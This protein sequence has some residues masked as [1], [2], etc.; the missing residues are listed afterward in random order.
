VPSVLSAWWPFMLNMASSSD[1][2]ERSSTHSIRAFHTPA[3]SCHA[4]R[5]G[6]SMKPIL[7]QADSESVPSRWRS[8]RMMRMP[9]SLDH[10]T[11]LPESDHLMALIAPSPECNTVSLPALPPSPIAP[12]QPCAVCDAELVLAFD[13]WPIG[14]PTVWISSPAKPPDRY[15]RSFL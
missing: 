3:I 4:R 8:V 10:A 2:S 9:C 5:F 11:N 13:F 7:F 15:E 1:S 12:S 14:P 6:F